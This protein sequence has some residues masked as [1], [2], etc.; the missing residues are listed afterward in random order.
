MFCVNKSAQCGSPSRRREQWTMVFLTKSSVS[1]WRD[2]ESDEFWTRSIQPG[3]LIQHTL[4]ETMCVFFEKIENERLIVKSYS[5]LFVINDKNYQSRNMNLGRGAIHAMASD[6][7]RYFKVIWSIF[8][9]LGF[10]FLAIQVNLK[11]NTLGL[12]SR[13]KLIT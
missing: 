1:F 7:L 13:C 12:L 10:I 3:T 4:N 9:H 2:P 6:N 5:K 11:Q 8:K